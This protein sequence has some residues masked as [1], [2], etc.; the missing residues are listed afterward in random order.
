MNKKLKKSSNR[1][2][3]YII[4]CAHDDGF[5]FKPRIDLNLLFTLSFSIIVLIFFEI[6]DFFDTMIYNK[7]ID[8]FEYY[9]IADIIGFISFFIE[10]KTYLIYCSYHVLWVL[11]RVQRV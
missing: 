7:F 6:I 2:L 10:N 1:K 5:Y 4:S 3:N 9:A 8:D 11:G